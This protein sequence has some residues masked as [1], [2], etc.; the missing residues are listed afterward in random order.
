MFSKKALKSVKA[1]VADIEKAKERAREEGS[2]GEDQT[3]QWQEVKEL[4]DAHVTLG[5]RFGIFLLFQVIHQQKMKDYIKELG[6]ERV[7]IDPEDLKND[8]AVM[9]ILSDDDNISMIG[10]DIQK[11]LMEAFIN[12]DHTGHAQA[13]LMGH[14]QKD[15][16]ELVIAVKSFSESIDSYYE[17][18]HKD[19]PDLMSTT[20]N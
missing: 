19:A 6:V 12:D 7:G 16:E 9:R 8:D 15:I 17:E 3:Y 5:C 20:I 4:I 18:H 1:A 10:D 2:D 13:I 11:W 14:A